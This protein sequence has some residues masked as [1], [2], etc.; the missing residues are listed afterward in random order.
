[1][2][3]I[4]RYHPLL[5]TLHWVLAVLI[6]A[7]LSSGFFGLAATSNSDPQKIGLLRV[8]MPGGVLIVA[9]T[10]IRFILRRRTSRPVE[11]TTGYPLLERIAPISYY[12]LYIL[13]VLIVGTGFATAVIAG[14]GEIVFGPSGVPLPDSLMIYPTFVAHVLFALLLVGFIILHVL[15]AL[16]HQFVKKDGLLLR[17]PSG[18][19]CQIPRLLSKQPPRP[20]EGMTAG[21]NPPRR[22]R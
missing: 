3:Q 2:K 22:G 11:A 19:V 5:V 7:E 13:I 14:L 17:C 4:S 21:F 15:A 1:M 12:G 16:Y 6:I 10:V 20:C 8:H 9:L 18:D